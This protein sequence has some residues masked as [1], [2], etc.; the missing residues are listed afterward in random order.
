M[1]LICSGLGSAGIYPTESAARIPYLLNDSGA[2]IVFVDNANQLSK[3]LSARPNCPGVVRIVVFDD[4][5]AEDA[6]DPMVVSFSRWC[7]RGQQIDR[8]DPTG[9]FDTID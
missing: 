1:G 3:I 6:K 4:T 8:D 7:E 5:I 2:K 9:W